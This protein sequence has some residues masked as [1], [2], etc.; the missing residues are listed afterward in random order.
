MSKGRVRV[1]HKKFLQGDDNIKDQPK[2]GW[3]KTACS[4]DKVAAVSEYL[5]GKRNASLRDIAAHINVSMSSVH[6]VVKKDLKLSKLSPKF[7]PKELTQQQKDTRLKLCQDNI[8]LM[9][10]DPD[11]LSKIVTRDE[12][13]VSVFEVPTKRESSQWLP[14]GTHLNRPLKALPQRTERKSMLTVFFDGDRVILSEFAPAGEN[15]TSD[16]YIQVLKNLK[17]RLRR[18]RPHLWIRE[19]TDVSHPFLLHH[20]NASSHTS[21]PTL[22]FIGESG[23][24]MLAHP[25][26]SPDLAPCDFFL[27][28]RLK[29][30]LRGVRHRN[31][32]DMQEAVKKALKQIPQEDFANAINCMP[33]RWMKCV[34]AQGDYFEGRHITIDPEGNHELFFGASS[35]EEEDSEEN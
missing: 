7:V 23:I 6:R 11:S 16:S 27:F 33:M 24:D 17:E 10:T 25:P 15:V 14:K 2:S 26:Y 9:K 28:P 3:P 8:N 31:I 22:A 35:S 13:W 21:V 4:A 34:A 12:S 32:K 20:D 30:I 18:K 29:N 5:E 1:W 19:S